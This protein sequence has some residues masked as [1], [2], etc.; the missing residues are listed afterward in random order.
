MLINDVVFHGGRFI[1]TGEG[2]DTSQEGWELRVKVMELHHSMT[3]REL[4]RRVRR[5]QKGRVLDVNGSAS[6]YCFGYRS[7]FADSNWAETLAACG[8]K[9]KRVVVIYEP[10]A[11][12]V[13]LIFVLFVDGWSIGAIARKLT[14]EKVPKGLRCTKPEWGHQRVRKIFG[15]TKYVGLWPWGET[16]TVRDSRA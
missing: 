13:R 10:E 5:G 14:D 7:E 16:V 9:P 3:I 4:G 2:I 1:S 8:P 12:V 6:D 15:N 11:E